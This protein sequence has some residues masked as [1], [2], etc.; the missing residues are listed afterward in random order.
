MIPK[1][2]REYT[3]EVRPLLILAWIAVS[4]LA[5]LALIWLLRIDVAWAKLDWP[6]WVQAVGSVAA[7]MAAVWISNQQQMQASVER[8]RLSYRYLFRAYHAGD[9]AVA[10]LV[11]VLKG[12]KEGDVLPSSLQYY[13]HSLEDVDRNLADFSFKE[14]VDYDFASGFML[15]RRHVGMAKSRIEHCLD[16]P[17]EVASY[18]NVDKALESISPLSDHLKE[19]FEAHSQRVG[20]RVYKDQH[21]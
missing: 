10:C 9:D 3:I 20:P 14:M 12:I 2:W 1:E 8:Q 7:I 6:A 17:S 18:M 13:I 5:V 19:L 15:V 21:L 16:K 11:H 4:P